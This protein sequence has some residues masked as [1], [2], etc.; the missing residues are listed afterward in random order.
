CSNSLSYK[1]KFVAP[2][3]SKQQNGRSG[4]R[5]CFVKELVTYMVMDDLVVDLGINE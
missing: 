4:T 2:A 1:K 3:F 5:R